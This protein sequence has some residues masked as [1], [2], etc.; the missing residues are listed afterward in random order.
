[1]IVLISSELDQAT[2]DI[3]DWLQM[4]KHPFV[5]LNEEDRL[6]I[7]RFSIRPYELTIRAENLGMELNLTSIGAVWYRR[8][9]LLFNIDLV[10]LESGVDEV[11]RARINEY[12]IDENRTLVDAIYDAFFARRS[13]NSID[14]ARVN[15]LIILNRA[16]RCGLRIPDTL[17]ASSVQQISAFRKKH[18]RIIC[19]PLHIGLRNPVGDW[20]FA[21]FTEEVTTEDLISDEAAIRPSF[22]QELIVKELDLRIF[23]IRGC[24]YASAIFSQSSQ[25]TSIDFR[26]YDGEMPNRTPPF[27]LPSL[28]SQKI[29]TLM[30]DLDIECGSIDMVLS[31]TGEY[32]FLEVNPVGQFGQVSYP[33]N[34][35]LER[36]ISNTLIHDDKE[37][38]GVRTAKNKD[39]A[40][41]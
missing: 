3:V 27:Q 41:N 15:K 36:T 35:Y 20:Q 25:N 29:H 6:N 34:Y 13:L 22:L 18:G 19:K 7:E 17:V 16:H 26:D 9:A 30:K 11:L 5:R 39:M 12:L 24:C 8:G 4:S 1:M 14:D 28:V 32:V 37:R 31:T 23:Y 21:S 33:C 40:S 10:P 38:L 2:N